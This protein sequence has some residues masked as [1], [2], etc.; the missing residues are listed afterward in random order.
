M[1]HDEY[2]DPSVL[3]HGAEPEYSAMRAMFPDLV[4]TGGLHPD[5]LRSFEGW[6]PTGATT[7]RIPNSSE[8][9]SVF[10]DY[11]DVSE[12]GLTG[13][14]R[15]SSPEL[16]AKWVERVVEEACVGFVD[17]YDERTRDVSWAQ[18]DRQ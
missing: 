4:K 18:P 8:S 16:A 14:P 10:W 3:G 12:S 9:G 13:D 1:L 11:A 17:E 7:A 2:P 5:H 6:A 15:A